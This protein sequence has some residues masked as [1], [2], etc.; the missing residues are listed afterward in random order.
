MRRRSASC[1]RRSRVSSA[2]SRSCPSPFTRN[3]RRRSKNGFPPGCSRSAYASRRSCRMVSTARSF[4]IE[5]RCALPINAEVAPCAELT[6]ERLRDYPF[7]VMGAEHMVTR[8]LREAFH[9]AGARAPRA[10]S[11]RPFPQRTQ[12][13]QRG[14]R[15]GA[16]RP[17]HLGERSGGTVCRPLFPAQDHARP[18][19]DHGPR[20]TALLGRTRVP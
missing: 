13:G 15:R 5:M 16:D 2:I 11:D 19:I 8:R 1:L 14:G 12:H 18:R 3:T 9:N 7:I 4:H 20:S 6:P 17:V 10:L